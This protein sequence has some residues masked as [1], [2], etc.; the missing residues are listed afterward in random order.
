MGSTY[1]PFYQPEVPGLAGYEDAFELKVVTVQK[2]AFSA[3]Q[4]GVQKVEDVAG[5]K[6]TLNMVSKPLCM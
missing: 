1:P 6:S 4:S 2:V 5:M 3:S